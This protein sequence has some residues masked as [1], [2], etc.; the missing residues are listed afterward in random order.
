MNAV[1]STPEISVA[2]IW[3]R[4]KDNRTGRDE[5]DGALAAFRLYRDLSPASRSLNAVAL[6]LH[7]KTE[8]QAGEAPRSLV[9][10]VEKWSVQWGWFFRAGAWDDEQDRLRREDQSERLRTAVA[11]QRQDCQYASHVLMAGVKKMLVL[12]QADPTLKSVSDPQLARDLQRV[13]R[14]FPELQKAERNLFALRPKRGLETDPALSTE[15]VEWEWGGLYT[16]N[17]GNGSGEEKRKSKA[18]ENPERSPEEPGEEGGKEDQGEALEAPGLRDQLWVRQV[19]LGT[20]KP[21]PPRAFHAF[22][23][24][25]DLPPHQ[26]TLREVTALLRGTAETKE[27]GRPAARTRRR[28]HVSATVEGWSA[29]F[30]WKKRA[31]AWDDEQDRVRRRAEQ[32]EVERIRLEH[33]QQLQIARQVARALIG[34]LSKRT[35]GA[36]FAGDEAKLVRCASETIPLLG[37]LQEAE[38]ALYE[39]GTDYEERQT[40]LI[41]KTAIFCWG[42]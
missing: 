6:A 24:F 20:G 37:R 12:V 17:S 27:S 28:E 39:G 38:R 34:A 5:P 7:Q 8:P 16:P 19:D 21:E 11:L 41:E 13:V 10:Q 33:G 4:L 40:M 32:K 25:R 26:R 30:Q 15:I 1:G 42:K 31:Q 36:F 14:A 29:E 3:E 23:L 18:V 9:R 35:R 22:T 2:P